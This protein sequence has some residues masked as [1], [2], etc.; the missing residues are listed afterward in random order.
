LGLT[1]LLGLT[2]ATILQ[3]PLGRVILGCYWFGIDQANDKKR[4]LLPCSHFTALLCFK[5]GAS[6]NP[7]QVA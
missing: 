7:C 6:A 2:I 5:D 4:L 3:S 1:A